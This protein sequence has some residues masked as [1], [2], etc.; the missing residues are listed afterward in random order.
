MKLQWFKYS[1]CSSGFW[2]YSLVIEPIQ[3]AVGRPPAPGWGLEVCIA[4]AYRPGSQR[5]DLD[6]PGM[7]GILCWKV[8]P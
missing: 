4:P 7:P 3:R 5:S 1:S 8:R 6:Q 2:I